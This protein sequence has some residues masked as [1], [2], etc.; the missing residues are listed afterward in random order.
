M[1]SDAVAFLKKCEPRFTIY[2]ERIGDIALPKRR[3]SD[4]FLAL[5]ESIAYQQLA[6]AAARVI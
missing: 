6:G 2:I 1:N 3:S 4:P 5:I